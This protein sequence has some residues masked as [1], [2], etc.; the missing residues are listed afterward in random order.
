M[1]SNKE[2]H[3]QEDQTLHVDKDNVVN[4]SSI[5]TNI[6]D[7]DVRKKVF[8][9]WMDAEFFYKNYSRR[10]GFGIRKRDSQMNNKGEPRMQKWVCYKEGKTNEAGNDIVQRKKK[11]SEV[12]Q[13]C[14]AIF[15]VKCHRSIDDS[16]LALAKAMCTVGIKRV[17][18]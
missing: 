7:D 13:E 11:H 4:E 15:H 3:T 1:E 16:E 18:L 12:R 5:F 8:E 9:S 10:V 6:T 14:P 17:K 2:H